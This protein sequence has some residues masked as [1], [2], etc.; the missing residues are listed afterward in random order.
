MSRTL[1]SKTGCHFL[2]FRFFKA[3]ARSL[4]KNVV[5]VRC[6]KN[7]VSGFQRCH[8]FRSENAR[9]KRIRK[10]SDGCRVMAIVTFRGLA[11]HRKK[12]V[13]NCLNARA[14]MTSDK[15]DD[16]RLLARKTNENKMKNG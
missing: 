7:H 16:E 13:K 8:W 1:G 3:H 14:K 6:A 2:G 11:L 15:F 9:E 10:R 4:A 12:P 5:R